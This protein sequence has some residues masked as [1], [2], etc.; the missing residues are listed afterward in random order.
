M[1]FLN[2]NSIVWV[3]LWLIVGI[4]FV[5]LAIAGIYTK[6]TWGRFGEVVYRAK[7]PRAFWVIILIYYLIGLYCIVRFGLAL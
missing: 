7:E 5:S 1:K 6:K 4:V 2:S 3:Y